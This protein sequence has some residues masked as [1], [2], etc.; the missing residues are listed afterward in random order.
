MNCVELIGNL[1]KDPET[2]TTTGNN[3]ISV[4]RFTLA[5][6]DRKIDPKTGDWVDD[7]DFIPITVWGKSAE[8]CDRY[9]RKG[10]KCSVEGKI[11]TGS[12]EKDGRKIYTT[13]V[14]ARNVGFLSQKEQKE[15]QE[16]DEVP[17]GFHE[18]EEELPF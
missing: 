7:T 4:C 8:N 10:S 17:V 6:N 16:K 2:R 13:D 5:V 9:L 15:Q 18:V 14:V 1:T 12:Y 11:K 3:P